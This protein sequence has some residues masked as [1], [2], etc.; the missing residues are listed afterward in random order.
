MG[1]VNDQWEQI[2]GNFK[3]DVIKWFVFT[4][5][6][7]VL[8]LIVGYWQKLAHHPAS[9]L[10]LVLIPLV[11]SIIMSTFALVVNKVTP[12][13]VELGSTSGPSPLLLLNVTNKGKE[14][15]FTAYAEITGHPN[16]VNLPKTGK[17]RLEWRDNKTTAQTITHGATESL[18]IA[19]FEGTYV[20]DMKEA[21]VW[22]SVSGLRTKHSSF[23]WYTT[24]DEP[25]PA[26]TLKITIV[27]DKAEEPFVKDFTLRPQRCHGPLELIATEVSL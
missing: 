21:I 3:Y 20:T 16:G 13:N 14:M 17:F 12:L 2:R 6:V 15:L 4:G 24:K 25:L 18:V 7:T 23:R 11:G 5:G 19:T 1:W 22:E 10:E 27:G 26:F 9:S 8:G